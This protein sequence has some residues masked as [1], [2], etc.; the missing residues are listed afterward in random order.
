MKLEAT[1]SNHKFHKVFSNT[2]IFTKIK[3]FS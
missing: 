2:N 3:I 1:H